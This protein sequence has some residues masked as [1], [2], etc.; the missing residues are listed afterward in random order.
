MLS[1]FSNSNGE[2][3]TPPVVG[4]P[5]IVPSNGNNNGGEPVAPGPVYE[6]GTIAHA[7]HAATAAAIAA[8]VSAAHAAGVPN[9]TIVRAGQGHPEPVDVINLDEAQSRT[10][11]DSIAQDTPMNVPET[12]SPEPSAPLSESTSQAPPPDTPDTPDTPSA[13]PSGSNVRRL[14]AT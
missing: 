6:A 3:P 2:S 9:I 14:V 5:N 4:A 10:E 1:F 11:P 12:S 8:A 13:E 7:A